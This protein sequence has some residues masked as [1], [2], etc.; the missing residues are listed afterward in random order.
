MSSMT[1]LLFKAWRESRGRFLAS[2]VL[3]AA[4]CVSGVFCRGSLM[5]VI[6]PDER[7]AGDPYV[8][9]IYSLVYAGTARGLF[10]I[11]AMVLALGGLQREHLHQTVGFTLALPVSRVR[12]VSIQAL[13]GLG[14]VAILSVLPMVLLAVCSWLVHAW[15]P[16]AQ[17]ARFGLLWFAG[18][19]VFFAVAFLAATLFRSDYTALA[20]AFVFAVFY[21]TATIV[22]PLNRY[23]LN[24]HH[25]MNGM[26]MPYFDRHT[27]LLVGSPPWM[28]LAFMLAI[29]GSL[30]AVAVQIAK[31]RD[32]P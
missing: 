25:V 2:A 29:A 11:M 31:R 23:P 32:Y 17:M 14:Q 4:V 3:L 24:I 28:L 7:F 6:V 5:K 19:A 12:L 13:S 18:G 26:S 16:L 30:I 9:Y 27:A 22:P 20:V 8:G 15:Y 21:P 1:P 10:T